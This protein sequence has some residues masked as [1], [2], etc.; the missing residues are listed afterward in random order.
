VRLSLFYSFSPSPS[1]P[2]AL[3][4]LS[5]L[6]PAPSLPLLSLLQTFAE[7][8][9]FINCFMIAKKPPFAAISIGVSPFLLALLTDAYNFTSQKNKKIGV[10]F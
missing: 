7:V 4:L 8:L 3:P 10:E 5:P 6:P 1:L 9:S 2:L